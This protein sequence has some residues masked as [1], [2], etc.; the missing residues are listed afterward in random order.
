VARLSLY[1][2]QLAR[3]LRQGNQTVSSSQLGRALGI[4]DAQVRKDL[5][6]FGQFGYPGIG[7]RVPELG[8]AIRH[9]LGTDRAWPVALVGVGNLG[10]ALLGYRGF[11]EQGF[12]VAAL[13]DSDPAKV[14]TICEGIRIEPLDALAR[15]LADRAIRLAII[16]VPADAAQGVADRLV[17]A[18]I[19]GILNFAPATISLPEHV[20]L[21]G[22]DLTVQLEQLSFLIAGGSPAAAAEDDASQDKEDLGQRAESIGPKEKGERIKKGI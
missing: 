20:H 2:R 7:Y 4:T 18:R 8:E 14:G 21:V 17:A 10:R 5:A 16:A 22:V 1:L 13:F 3:L 9:I 19:Q 6:Y 11:R 12:Q 15:V